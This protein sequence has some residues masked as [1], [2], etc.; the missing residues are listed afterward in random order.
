VCNL[1]A[2][3][4]DGSDLLI[5]Q[6]LKNQVSTQAQ[7]VTASTALANIA[8]LSSIYSVGEHSMW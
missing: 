7:P 8:A 2:V 5:I 6:L 1:W 4:S 3:I